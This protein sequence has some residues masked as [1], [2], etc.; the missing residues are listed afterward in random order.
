MILKE[1]RIENFGKIDCF[2]SSFDPRLTVL[3]AKYADD[4]IKAIGVVTDNQTLSG[5]E[6][7]QISSE[8]THISAVLEIHGNIFRLDFTGRL[9]GGKREAF[10]SGNNH[11]VNPA[12]LLKD[13]HL[14][15]EEESLTYYRFDCKNEYSDL[16]LKY[17]EYDKYYSCGEFAERTDGIGITKSFRAYLTRYIREKRTEQ[18]TSFGYKAELLPSGKF[19]RRRAENCEETD[20]RL[21]D[22]ACYLGVK[23]FWEQFENIRNMNYEKWPSIVDAAGCEGSS[24]CKKLLFLLGGTERQLIILST[25]TIGLKAREPSS[26]TDLGQVKKRIGIMPNF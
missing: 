7:K 16:L 17:R 13:I 8:N 23:E 18:P 21:F 24:E 6:A 14:C 4:V 2:E 26:E 12:E 19:V 1:L 15:Q 3:S 22:Y 11:F 9:Q 25:N 10:V 5:S 20:N